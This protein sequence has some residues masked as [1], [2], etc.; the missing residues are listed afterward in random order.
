M[1]D[2]GVQTGEVEAVENVVLF[3]LTKIFVALRREEPRNPLSPSVKTATCGKA[4]RT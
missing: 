2:V 4:S 3:D 1:L